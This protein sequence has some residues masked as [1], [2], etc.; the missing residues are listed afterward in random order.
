MDVIKQKKT[1]LNKSKWPTLIAAGAVLVLLA[2]MTSRANSSVSVKRSDLLFA[3]VQQGDLDVVVDGY[4]VLTSDKQ[5]LITSF[6]AATVKEIVLKPGAQVKA[7]SV[8]AIL[9]N[10]INERQSLI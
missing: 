1:G 3:T 5:Q 2:I 6:S 7:N 8:I 4:G 10:E 9:E